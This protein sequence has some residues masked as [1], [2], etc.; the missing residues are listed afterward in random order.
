MSIRATVRRSAPVVAA[1][2]AAPLARPHAGPLAA[3]LPALLAALLAAVPGA[4]LGVRMAR[5]E[6]VVIDDK[7]SVLP[8]D[9]A[10]PA[11]GMT[12]KTVEERFGVP[13]ERHPT[14]GTPPITRWDY[15]AFAVFFEKDRVIHAV[16]LPAP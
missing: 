12:M 6:T 3:S 9:I 8:S 4:L 1:P 5:A 11:A 14:I 2:L 13:Q 7:V 10:R 15:P 16:V